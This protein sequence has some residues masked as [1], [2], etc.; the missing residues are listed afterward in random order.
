M[1]LSVQ[2]QATQNIQLEISLVTD[3][4]VD[5]GLEDMAV[6]GDM[7]SLIIGAWLGI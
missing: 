2:T 6:D 3:L 4:F 5:G 7:N 1:L